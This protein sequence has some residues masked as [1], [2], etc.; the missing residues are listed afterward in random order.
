MKKMTVVGVVA[1]SLWLWPTAAFAVDMVLFNGK[2]FTASDAQPFADAV[3]IDGDRIAAVGD[4]ASVLALAG[5]STRVI[6]LSGHTVVPGFNDTHAH[7]LVNIGA[8]QPP[9]IAFPGPGPTLDE[10]LVQL[11]S[12]VAVAAPDQWIVVLVGNDPIFDDE[13]SRFVLD[14]LA[15][16]NPAVFLHHASHVALI[17]TRAMELTGLAEDAPDPFAGFYGRIDG[18]QIIDGRLFEYALFGFLR[19]ARRLFPIEQL[20]AGYSFDSQVRAQFGYTSAQEIPIGVEPDREAA[21]LR[22]ADLKIRVR[23]MCQPLSVDQSCATDF[24]N[25][26]ATITA[27][28]IKWLSD[29]TLVERNAAFFDPYADAPE[30][31]GFFAFAPPELRAILERSVTGN[32]VENQPVIHALGDR[33]VSNILDG[34]SAL[35]GDAFWRSRRLRIEH[36]ELWEP[37]DMQQAAAMGVILVQNPFVAIGLAGDSFLDHLGPERTARVV[38]L[39]SA[40]DAGIPVALG[41]DFVLP[42]PFL[43]IFFAVA[44]PLNPNEAITV[45]EAVIA[46]T[47]TAAYAEF[48]EHHKGQIRHGFLADLTVLSQDIFTV[49][50]FSIPAT[51]SLLTIMDGDVTWDAGVLL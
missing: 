6:D 29:G 19:R 39:R 23:F 16:D 50:A 1:V 46:Y 41:Q 5:A 12:A 37:G 24:N 49:P 32:P 51:V 30:T 31:S 36:G 13:A 4:D 38:P 9:P 48:Q 35:A 2:V 20:A 26:T 11:A 22:A 33:A 15:P 17:N 21:T 14:V 34:M 42:N 28:G 45:E 18:T 27:G 43:D 3:A 10:A 25:P 47:R 40:L 44:H 8:I 7:F